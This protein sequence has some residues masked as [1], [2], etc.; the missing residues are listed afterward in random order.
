MI[1]CEVR[2]RA[3]ESEDFQRET[4]RHSAFRLTLGK[5]QI[6][7]YMN[8]QFLY[9]KQGISPFL[10][11]PD[12][13]DSETPVKIA[14]YAGRVCLPRLDSVH[15]KGDFQRVLAPSRWMTSTLPE[16]YERRYPMSWGYQ[17]S[18]PGGESAVGVYLFE[19]GLPKTLSAARDRMEHVEKLTN[20]WFERLRNWVEILTYQDLSVTEP[21]GP[22]IPYISVETRSIW[23]WKART[24]W[25]TTSASRARFDASATDVSNAI[26]QEIWLRAIQSANNETLP[27]EPHLLLRDARARLNR[28]QFRYSALFSAIA[29]E[30]VLA[31]QIEHELQKRRIPKPFIERIL[32]GTLGRLV[33]DCKALDISLPP[34][35]K[36]DLIQ[37]RNRAAHGNEGVMVTEAETRKAL[38][39]AT[40]VITEMAPL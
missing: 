14:G 10:F 19:F 11:Q 37:V 5:V 25:R 12:V 17:I 28:R 35:V 22:P 33:E 38:E 27:P 8:A 15:S 24:I 23:S 18:Q 36:V 13:L 34:T 26:T 39:V 9:T 16:V 31:K 40:K 6:G 20:S 30:M 2:F 21:L 4:S 3:N 7:T 32:S 1:Y 29:T